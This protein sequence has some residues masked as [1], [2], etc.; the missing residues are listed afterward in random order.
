MQRFSKTARRAALAACVAA[1][2]LLSGVGIAMAQNWRLAPRYG[3]VN[4]RG[5][6]MPDPHTISLTAGG[7]INTRT[8]GPAPACGYV[9]NN[10]D[11]RLNW[12]GGGGMLNIY[13][14]SGSD[15]TLL[16]NMPNGSWFCNDD[17]GQGTNPL[18]SFAG[19]QAG[20][21][22]IFVGTY[23]SSTAPA[24]LMISELSPRW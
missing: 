5:G 2:V 3:T 15:T 20:Q 24:A 11:V 1:V 14:R 18:A 13:V 21:Y 22:D 4:L 8:S 16:I 9:A 12:G 6:F 7:P 10:P 17:G 19:S 23:T